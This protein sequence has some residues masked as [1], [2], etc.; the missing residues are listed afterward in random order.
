L[1][2]FYIYL[3]LL[4]SSLLALL[5]ALVAGRHYGRAAAERGLRLRDHAIS[6]EQDGLRQ[7]AAWMDRLCGIGVARTQA[8]AVFTGVA[9]EEGSFKAFEPQDPRVDVFPELRSHLESGYP[10]ILKQWEDLKRVVSGYNIRLI[11]FLERL[12]RELEE[13][14]AIPAYYGVGRAPDRSVNTAAIVEL[15][16]HAVGDGVSEPTELLRSLYIGGGEAGLPYYLGYPGYTYL[17]RSPLLTDIKEVNSLVRQFVPSLFERE[18]FRRLV[19]EADILKAQRE[20]LKERI[21][22]VARAVNLGE[23]LKGMCHVCGKIA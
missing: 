21:L 3:G 19:E 20:K 5:V 14:L 4:L 8:A 13:G 6:L 11:V 17:A 15:V 18:E 16:F 12:K 22:G 7:W 23:Q 10:D 2:D 9:R 1:E